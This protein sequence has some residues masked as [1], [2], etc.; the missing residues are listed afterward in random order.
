MNNIFSYPSAEFHPIRDVGGA[1]Q[2][3]SD[4]FLVEGSTDYKW[5]S[6]EQEYTDWIPFDAPQSQ[7]ITVLPPIALPKVKESP[8]SS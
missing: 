1:S 3:S 7:G 8:S 2:E 6:A 4:L 5:V